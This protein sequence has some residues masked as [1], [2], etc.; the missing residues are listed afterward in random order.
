[1]RKTTIVFL[2]FVALVLPAPLVAHEDH[3]HKVMGT[4]TNVDASHVELETADGKKM[5]AQF[6]KKTKFLQGKSPATAAD[7]KVGVRIALK[8]IEKDGQ[9]IA[10]EVRLAAADDEGKTAK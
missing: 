2:L 10:K 1:M 5:S 4:V 3:E 9:Q 8:L 7:I 6:D